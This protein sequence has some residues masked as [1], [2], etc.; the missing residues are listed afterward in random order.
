MKAEVAPTLRHWKIDTDLTGIRDIESLAKLPEAE[1]AALRT[2][3]ADVE[4]HRK[5]AE[6]KSA[7]IR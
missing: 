3:W 5:K 7:A 2:L 6:T 1:R 4:T